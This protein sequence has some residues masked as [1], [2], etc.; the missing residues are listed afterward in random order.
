MGFLWFS[1]FAWLIAWEFLGISPL[2]R[3]KQ[4]DVF[5][6]DITQPLRNWFKQ[7]RCGESYSWW[8]HQTR[9][10]F[11]MLSAPVAIFTNTVVDLWA[12]YRHLLLG[13]AGIVI[14]QRKKVSL[15]VE[16]MWRLWRWMWLKMLVMMHS[17]ARSQRFLAVYS[18]IIQIA[19]WHKENYLWTQEHFARS[20]FSW[21]LSLGWINRVR[22]EESRM[23]GSF[24]HVEWWFLWA[25]LCLGLVP[26]LKISKYQAYFKQRSAESYPPSPRVFT[27]SIPLSL[28]SV[29][30]RMKE[31]RCWICPSK[32]AQ[33]V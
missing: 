20:F 5:F 30:T 24:R 3:V 17:T 22:A 6:S 8:I 7:R 28:S 2:I 18:W 27:I 13:K 16:K 32:L 21:G 19:W 33:N 12:W 10:P 15:D 1:C 4:Q 11:T 25:C 9:L 23:A 31:T 29:H 26:F 14:R